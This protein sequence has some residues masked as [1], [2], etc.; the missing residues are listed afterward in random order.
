[1]ELAR[2][3]AAG[4]KY[5][6]DYSNSSSYF[7][8]V[9]HSPLPAF[10][11]M[12]AALK[13]N[14]LVT[15]PS[16][17]LMGYKLSLDPR[18]AS[19]MYADGALNYMAA[20]CNLVFRID[21]TLPSRSFSFL[22]QKNHSILAKFSVKIIENQDFIRHT[23]TKYRKRAVDQQVKKCAF[24]T[25]KDPQPGDPLNIFSFQSILYLVLCGLCAG[26]VCVL[27]EKAWHR[28]KA[29]TPEGLVEVGPTFDETTMRPPIDL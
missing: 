3:I 20:H 10:Q 24:L 6:L 4:E 13:R 14:P 1:M 2:L 9:Q 19:P 25:R 23:A 7:Y 26:I 21:Q 17:K 18:A 5:L 8:Q 27:S 11:S 28:W 12:K 15:E 16:S 29:L 22:F